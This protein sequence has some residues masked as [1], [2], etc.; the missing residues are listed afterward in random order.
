[1]DRPSELVT[2]SE[3]KR[4]CSGVAPPRDL[5]DEAAVGGKVLEVAPA[6]QS[7]ASSIALFRLPWALSMAPFSWARPGLLPVGRASA[8]LLSK[9][10]NAA[11]SLS[12][13]CKTM[14]RELLA[15]GAKPEVARRIAANSRRWWRNSGILLSAM[16]NLKWA[17]QLGVPRF[18]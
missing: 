11:E 9:L 3:V 14:Y 15:L 4:N 5:V 6:A 18:S 17:D 1:V 2:A 12:L 7:N 13:R 16:L 8:A 10:Q